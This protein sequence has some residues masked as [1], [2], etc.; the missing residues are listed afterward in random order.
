LRRRDLTLR[1][2]P[3]IP[4][5][6]L[7]AV[8]LDSSSSN[9]STS[10][11]VN[12]ERPRRAVTGS[13]VA[14]LKRKCSVMCVLSVV[15]AFAAVFRGHT[16]GALLSIPNSTNLKRHQRMMMRRCR[17][18]GITIVLFALCFN[19][20]PSLRTIALAREHQFDLMWRALHR[21]TVCYFVNRAFIFPLFNDTH[22]LD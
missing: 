7:I 13:C 17:S 18:P 10:A 12:Q 2:V 20:C 9:R 5:P 16:N 3:D 4:P 14:Q 1:A 15:C 22:V 21:T 6:Q 11:N 19:L 8:A